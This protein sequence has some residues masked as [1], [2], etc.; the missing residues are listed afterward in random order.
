MLEIQIQQGSSWIRESK[1][2]KDMRQSLK[3]QI[4]SLGA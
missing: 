3:R 1:A 2:L 4:K